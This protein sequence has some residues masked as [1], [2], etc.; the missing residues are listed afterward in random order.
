MTKAASTFV[1]GIEGTEGATKYESKPLTLNGVKGRIWT[2][3][4]LKD[5]AWV[6]DGQRHIRA[7]ASEAEVCAEFAEYLA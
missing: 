3:R 6:L 1:I 2:R 4:V 5:H 7:G